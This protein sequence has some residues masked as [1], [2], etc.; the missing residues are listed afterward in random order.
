MNRSM[1]IDTGLQEYMTYVMSWMA[2]GTAV[3]GLVAVIL[4]SNPALMVFFLTGAM[5]WVTLLA[6]LAILFV[7]MFTMESMSSGMLKAVYLGF[8]GLMG[9]SLSAI[10]VTYTLGSVISVFI[11]TT[12][13]FG[14]LALWGYTTKRDLSGWGSFLFMGLIGI[15]ALA[16]INLFMASS[17]ISFAVSLAAVAIFSGFT[18]YDMQNI[19]ELYLSGHASEKG[20]ILGALNLYLNFVNLFVH[21]LSLLGDR[22]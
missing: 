5:K 20:A 2:G 14:S 16:V 10:F 18:A 12:V 11:L 4:A 8:T 21:L 1:S 6:P 13:M 9:L 19:K 22:D 3:S 17:A 15:I 7:L